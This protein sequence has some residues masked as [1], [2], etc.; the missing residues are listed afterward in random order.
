MLIVGLLGVLNL[1]GLDV[2]GDDLLLVGIES[3]CF[4][5]LV[6]YNNGVIARLS[7]VIFLVFINGICSVIV[8]NGVLWYKEIL[9][10]V[11]LMFGLFVCSCLLLYLEFMFRVLFRFNSAFGVRIVDFIVM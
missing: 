2:L 1:C 8:C 5:K 7:V 3:V 4:V 6:S 10:M 11:E 9:Y